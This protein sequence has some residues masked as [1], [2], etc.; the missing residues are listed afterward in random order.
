MR[1][2]LG[3]NRD[4][5]FL[6]ELEFP[7]LVDSPE[8]RREANP[9]NC[10]LE[11]IES[12]EYFDF[13]PNKEKRHD[14]LEVGRHPDGIFLG[15]YH[16]LGTC[17]PSSFE[18]TIKFARGVAVMVKEAPAITQVSDHAVDHLL[19]TTRRSN[20]AENSNRFLGQEIQFL[21]FLTMNTLKIART[22]IAAN[23]LSLGVV[24][25]NQ[26]QQVA[27]GTLGGLGDENIGSPGQVADGLA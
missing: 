5:F 6:N 22:M 4:D 8:S 12:L 25:M 1:G 19:E 26:I 17:V 16:E 23:D 13:H 2:S 9:R 21:P 18:N 27:V 10:G 3:G 14:R 24:L 15:S 7:E 20:G 11:I